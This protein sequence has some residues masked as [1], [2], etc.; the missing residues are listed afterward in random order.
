MTA[1]VLA[2]LLGDEERRIGDLVW[3]GSDT[4]LKLARPIVMTPISYADE[5]ADSYSRLGI[6]KLVP[7]AATSAPDAEAAEFVMYQNLDLAD[8][9]APGRGAVLS[10]QLNAG[11]ALAYQYPYYQPTVVKFCPEF[12]YFSFR[13]ETAAIAGDEEAGTTTAPASYHVVE[14]LDCPADHGTLWF[15]QTECMPTSAMAT[16]FA[17]NAYAADTAKRLGY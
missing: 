4:T 15:Q 12:Q 11:G 9:R 5:A 1:T 17:D 14:C 10:T 16:G 3:M 13:T 6:F 7:S 8:I 2:R